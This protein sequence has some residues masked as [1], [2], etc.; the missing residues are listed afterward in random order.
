MSF[1][2]IFATVVSGVALFYGIAKASGLDGSSRFMY[3]SKYG[4]ASWF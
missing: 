3:L 2:Y 4:V 1:L